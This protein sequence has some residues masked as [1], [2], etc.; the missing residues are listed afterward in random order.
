[1][2]ASAILPILEILFPLI[3]GIAL[4]L[5]PLIATIDTV[6]I[7]LEALGTMI[8]HIIT[9]Q[10][11]KLDDDAKK[12]ADR[13]T[14]AWEEVASNMETIAN[15][16]LETAN[17][18]SDAQKAY[19]DVVNDMYKSGLLTGQ[20]ALQMASI[21]LGT[22]YTGGSYQYLDKNTYAKTYSDGGGTVNIGSITIDASGKTM[23]QIIE[24]LRRLSYQDSVTG[25][26]A[27]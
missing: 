11:G 13:T 26:L 23:E 21:E 1:M 9:F 3:Q 4:I 15:A 20:E 19:L 17:R 14:E 22:Q 16:T 27:S 12:A 18:L 24:E 7:W 25:G 5:L 10:W 2:L 8:Y 6:I